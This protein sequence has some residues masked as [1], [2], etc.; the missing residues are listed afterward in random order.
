MT[1]NNTLGR[2]ISDRIL[3]MLTEQGDRKTNDFAEDLN[4]TMAEV[5][6]ELQTLEELDLIYRTGQTRAT[7][8]FLGPKPLSTEQGEETNN[9][10]IEP[11]EAESLA[12]FAQRKGAKEAILDDN[13]ALL[14]TVPDSEVADR[15]GVSLRTVAGYRAKHGIPGYVRPPYRKEDAELPPE[16]ETVSTS[17]LWKVSLAAGKNPVTSAASESRYVVGHV[18]NEV[19]DKLA[20]L[21]EDNVSIVEVTYVGVV[22]L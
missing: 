12:A 17:K 22:Y 4:V 14:G 11:S 1:T 18:W 6:D 15:L 19:A 7:R 5:R 9:F 3:S 2:M 8:W 21:E 10:E 16:K 13:V 20:A